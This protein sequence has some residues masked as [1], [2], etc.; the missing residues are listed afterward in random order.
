MSKQFFYD[1]E[2]MIW[3]ILHAINN[4]GGGHG[5]AIF[6]Q[7]LASLHDVAYSK[8]N[9]CVCKFKCDDQI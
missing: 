8:V 6:H 7:C 5:N 2:V 1:F 4:G 3:C 9:L